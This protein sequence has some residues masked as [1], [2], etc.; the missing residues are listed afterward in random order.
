MQNAIPGGGLGM[1]AGQVADMVALAPPE[2]NGANLTGT[3][4]AQVGD[5]LVVC[6]QYR[7]TSPTGRCAPYITGHIIGAPPPS[8]D[9]HRCATEWTGPANRAR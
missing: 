8:G 3:A 6:A 9:E 2:L 1:G 4:N 5:G 7:L